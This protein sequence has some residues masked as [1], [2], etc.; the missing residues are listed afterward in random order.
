MVFL[1]YEKQRILYYRR[2]GEELY[3]EITRRFI[4]EGR[5]ATKVGVLKFRR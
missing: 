1:D 4:E 2:L 5:R 3:V